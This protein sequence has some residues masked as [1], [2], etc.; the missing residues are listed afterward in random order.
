MNLFAARI[1]ELRNQAERLLL[2]LITAHGL[3]GKGTLD[4]RGFGVQNPSDGGYRRVLKAAGCI[5]GQ[6]SPDLEPGLMSVVALL[7]EHTRT[8]ASSV[9][10]TFDTWPNTLV[11]T[12]A[13][14]AP[15]LAEIKHALNCRVSKIELGSFSLEHGPWYVAP[16]SSRLRFVAQD[17][18][19]YLAAFAEEPRLSHHNPL[20]IC[21]YCH[22]VFLKGKTDQQFG[23]AKCRFA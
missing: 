21:H 13:Q 22:G 14:L 6:G 10:Q 8:A 20:G 11:M 19:R 5:G 3:K 4:P 9:K 1:I 17:L 23:S 18:V 16:T 12:E 15:A 2:A 7:Q